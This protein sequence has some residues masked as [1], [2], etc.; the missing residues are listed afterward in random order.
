MLKVMEKNFLGIADWVEVKPQSTAIS[1][2]ENQIYA[3]DQANHTNKYCLSANKSRFF[4]LERQ[5]H[6]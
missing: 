5:T 3:N 1:G 6:S 4:T 2:T